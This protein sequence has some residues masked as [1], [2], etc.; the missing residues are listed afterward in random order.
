MSSALI[1][2]A[3]GTAVATLRSMLAPHGFE[4]TISEDGSEADVQR[5]APDIILLRVELPRTNGFAVCN[6]LRRD[7]VTRKI[8]LIL[9]SSNAG[10][11]VMAQHRQLKTHADHYF[12]MPLDADHLVGAVKSVLRLPAAGSSISNRRF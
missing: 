8:P 2:D 1:I 7:E 11:E 9:Y 10:D 3:D 4:L 12:L 6:R 5:A